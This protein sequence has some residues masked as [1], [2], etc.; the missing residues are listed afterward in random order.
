MTGCGNATNQLYNPYG[1]ALHP[2]LGTLYIADLGNHR[3]MSYP[4]GAKNGTLLLGGTGPG[5]NNT[6]LRN[7]LGLYYDSFSSTLVI[8]NYGCNNIV[9]YA[10]GATSWT[11]VA[12]NIDGTSG[13]TSASFTAPTDVTFDPM[14]NMYVADRNNHRIQFFYAGQMNGTT[15][16]GVTS[17]NGSNATTL[18]IP[19]AAE[20]D[21][22]LNLYVA[23]GGNH[24]IQ[25][26]LRY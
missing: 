1:I 7:P 24:R 8:D 4:V 11:L 3:L 23:D 14:G 20:L 6:Q 26:F 21:S 16:A 25:K 2:T 18:N 9:R 22:Q 19:W 17:V 13:T 15:I 5:I 12:G 10:L